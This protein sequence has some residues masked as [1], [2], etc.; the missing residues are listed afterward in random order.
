[1][2]KYLLIGGMP[3]AVQT[4]VFTNDL[5]KVNEVQQKIDQYY[6]KDIVQYAPQQQ[7]VI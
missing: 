4:F 6:R 5:K 3:E 7:K 2:Y 1:M